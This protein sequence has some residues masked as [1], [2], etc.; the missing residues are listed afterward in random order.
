MKLF[1][2]LII[3]LV[4]LLLSWTV[5]GCDEKIVEAGEV[6]K[7]IVIEQGDGG[8]IILDDDLIIDTGQEK[9]LVKSGT[10]M[11]FKD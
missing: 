4:F 5:C 3:C 7:V 9:Y 1:E 8:Y 6:I 2:R 10:K 11:Y